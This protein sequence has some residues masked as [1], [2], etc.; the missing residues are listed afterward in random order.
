MGC[1]SIGFVG[2]AGFTRCI[3]TVFSLLVRAIRQTL[4]PSHGRVCTYVS[5]AQVLH[6]AVGVILHHL[7]IGAHMVI[8]AIGIDCSHLKLAILGQ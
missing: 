5:S 4:R 7:Q 6:K 2:E 8:Q 3:G 1:P